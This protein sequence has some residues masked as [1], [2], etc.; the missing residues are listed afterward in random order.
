MRWQPEGGQYRLTMQARA[1]GLVL[2]TQTSEGAIGGHGLEPV[3]F[4]DQRVRRSA[5]AANFDRATGRISYSGP[6]VT[7][8]LLAGTQDRLSLYLQVAGIA[9]AAGDVAAG[10]IWPVVVAGVRGDTAVWQLRVAGREPL[11]TPD[12]TVEALHLVRDA[13]NPG[14]T[15]ADIWLDPARHWLPIRASLRTAQGASEYD[16]ILRGVSAGS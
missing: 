8:P 2:L 9:A 12:G 15:V 7:H 4:V 10:T 6:A 1:G 16:L 14:D 13:R 11:A 3:R 5:Q